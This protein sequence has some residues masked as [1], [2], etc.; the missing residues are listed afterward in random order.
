MLVSATTKDA[1]QLQFSKTT[2]WTLLV[3]ALIV[4]EYVLVIYFFTMRARI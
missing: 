3:L 4:L 2:T 1:F